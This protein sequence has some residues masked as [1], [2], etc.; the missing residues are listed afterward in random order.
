MSAQKRRVLSRFTA[1]MIA[2]AAILLLAGCGTQGGFV[3]GPTSQ[4]RVRA[5]PQHLPGARIALTTGPHTTARVGANHLTIPTG[6]ITEVQGHAQWHTL[7]VPL[8]RVPTLAGM[9][10]A[11]VGTVVVSLPDAW[12]NARGH[13][14]VGSAK[15]VT[16]SVNQ[17]IPPKTAHGG[18]LTL[19]L[20]VQAVT[21]Q[22]RSSRTG[23]QTFILTEPAPHTL[24]WEN[25]TV[26]P[27]VS[28]AALLHQQE[29]N[30]APFSRHNGGRLH[31]GVQKTTWT[32]GPLTFH[33]RTRYVLNIQAT[34]DNVVLYDRG[35]HSAHWYIQQFPSLNWIAT[36]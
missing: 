4:Q 32:R 21:I 23:R 7:W 8:V 18:Q 16:L 28:K 20:Q 5:L 22:G 2:P 9:N 19:A 24:R 27:P 10:D 25:L 17:A 14:W 1:M 29:G 33:V 15:P 35:T 31:R 26:T 30:W 3:I 36:P 12:S 34:H 13:Q 11:V 6:D